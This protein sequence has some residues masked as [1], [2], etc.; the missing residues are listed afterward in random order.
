MPWVNSVTGTAHACQTD[1]VRAST[2][3]RARHAML[4][5]GS[6]LHNRAGTSAPLTK[7]CVLLTASSTTVLVRNASGAAS[8]APVTRGRRAH[9]S[10]VQTVAI[11]TAIALRRIRVR[12]TVVS[13]GQAV[14]SIVGVLDMVSAV[15]VVTVSATKGGDGRGAR[16]AVNGIAIPPIRWD[17]LVRDNPSAPLAAATDRALRASADVGPV[18]GAFGASRYN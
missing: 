6:T 16:R 15:Q 5:S 8:A 3:S 13:W 11:I 12:A 17:V 14:P 4:P 10:R 18:V 7:V 2:P 1:R 9:Y